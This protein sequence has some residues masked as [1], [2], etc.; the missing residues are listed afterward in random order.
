MARKARKSPTAER[1]EWGLG[2]ACGLL[3]AALVGYL[4]REGLSAGRTPPALTVAAEP[5]PEDE[6]RFT[7]RNDGGRTATAVALSL[8]LGDG[9]ERRLVI[10]YL[11]GHSDASGGFVLPEAAA[12]DAEIVVEGYLDP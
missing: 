9:A 6:M 3:V 10:D 11:P 5:A 7:V 8:S 4:A 2:L 1:L 12:P